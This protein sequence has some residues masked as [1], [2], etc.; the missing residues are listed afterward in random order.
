VTK[1]ITK[2]IT[3][4]KVNDITLE[5]YITI[6]TVDNRDCISL[7]HIS[8]K[9]MQKVK[10]PQNIWME[11]EVLLHQK[12][13]YIK[14]KKSWCSSVRTVMMKELGINHSRHTDCSL[15]KMTS[16]AA[17]PKGNRVSF[18]HTPMARTCTW[19]FTFIQ[20]QSTGIMVP[21]RWHKTDF[22]YGIYLKK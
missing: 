13:N 4:A 10:F 3:F 17:Y 5:I 11:K 8:G 6:P 1:T 21:F 19:S 15:H 18:P 2:T 12:L 9:Q 7:C 20:C 14:R 22:W 16:S